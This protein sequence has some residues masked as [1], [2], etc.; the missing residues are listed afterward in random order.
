MVE[1]AIALRLTTRF[2]TPLSGIPVNPRPLPPKELAEFK[3]VRVLVKTLAPVKV[4]EEVRSAPDETL[5]LLIWVC[6]DIVDR[7]R[8]ATSI[9][10]DADEI[11]ILLI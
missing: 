9:W 7:L 5:I 6:R 1:V 11:V 8:A 4:W 2:A 3:A 10:T